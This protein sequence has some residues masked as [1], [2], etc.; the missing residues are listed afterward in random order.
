MC[1]IGFSSQVS[2]NMWRNSQYLGTF[3]NRFQTMGDSMGDSMAVDMA[4][5]LD[6]E[7]VRSKRRKRNLTAENSES[8][9]IFMH[10]SHENKLNM[11]YNDI[12]E[13][14]LGQDTT[15]QGMKTFQNCFV[16]G[17]RRLDFFFFFFF[18]FFF[19]IFT[20]LETLTICSCNYFTF[21]TFSINPQST[22]VYGLLYRQGRKR[23]VL[24]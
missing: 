11:I 16:T 21:K 18:F 20:R 2:R 14:R 6:F 9:D 4:G 24:V 15:N 5:D 13:L 8:R 23:G 19:C 10:S 17:A 7:T 22:L 12:Q 1:L 3:H